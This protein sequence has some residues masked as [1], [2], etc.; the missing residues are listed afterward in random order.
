LTIQEFFIKIDEDDSNFINL[1]ELKAALFNIFTPNKNS[2]KEV[3]QFMKIMDKN[4][5]GVISYDEF[6]ETFR[7]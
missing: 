7:K 6:M 4:Q 5:N 3:L 2:L 1:A